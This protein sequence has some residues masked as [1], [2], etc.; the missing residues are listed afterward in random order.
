MVYCMK[1]AIGIFDVNDEVAIMEQIYKIWK[2][3]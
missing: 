2:I 1:K 3:E